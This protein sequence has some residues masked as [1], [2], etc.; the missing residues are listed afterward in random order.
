MYEVIHRFNNP[1]V[2]KYF[3]DKHGYEYVGYVH[4]DTT[5][6]ISRASGDIVANVKGCYQ[7]RE[8]REE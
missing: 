7:V 2:A 4:G 3:S 5:Y 8:M 6:A 1:R